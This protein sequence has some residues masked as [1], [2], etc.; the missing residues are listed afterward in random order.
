MIF[1]ITKNH[2]WGIHNNRLTFVHLC[3]LREPC[4]SEPGACFQ[5]FNLCN[6]ETRTVHNT[7]QPTTPSTPHIN[8]IKT[9]QSENI[10]TTD[11]QTSPWCELTGGRIALVP[12]SVNPGM[13]LR[14]TDRWLFRTEPNDSEKRFWETCPA[15]PPMP[16]LKPYVRQAIP[17][18]FEQ[19]CGTW[20]Y[21]FPAE[22]A[23]QRDVGKSLKMDNLKRFSPCVRDHTRS[24]TS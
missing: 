14:F 2:D 16:H 20:H 10:D 3:I 1:S 8:I 7:I 23:Q 21:I 17:R 22:A 15:F 13:R 18:N 12:V 5:C 24:H 19:P 6:T 4:S 9:R 11:M